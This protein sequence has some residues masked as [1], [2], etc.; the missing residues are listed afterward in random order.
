[1]ELQ[2]RQRDI[3]SFRVGNRDIVVIEKHLER[4]RTTTQ[5]FY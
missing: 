4:K 3:L 2:T 5:I 1:M